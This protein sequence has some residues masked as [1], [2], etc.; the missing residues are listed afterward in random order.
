MKEKIVSSGMLD[1]YEKS[2]LQFLDFAKDFNFKVH[3]RED[4]DKLASMWVEHIFHG[5]CH[6]GWGA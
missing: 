2:A 3:Q 6:K 1:R 5:G 4:L